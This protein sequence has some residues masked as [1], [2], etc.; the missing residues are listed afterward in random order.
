MKNPFY[1]FISSIYHLVGFIIGE[2]RAKKIKLLILEIIKSF[3]PKN[4]F[5]EDMKRLFEIAKRGRELKLHFGSDKRVLKGWINIDITPYDNSGEYAFP[6]QP[7]F[8]GAREDY[9]Q[10]DFRE[11]PL[12]V[13]DNSVELV[14]HEDFCKPLS[15]FF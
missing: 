12:P 8:R 10:I 4:T 3:Q 9:F 14:F 2:A 11:G 15:L 5:A 13:P 1:S 6:D 7:E